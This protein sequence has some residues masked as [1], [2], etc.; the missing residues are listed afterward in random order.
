MRGLV[1]CAEHLFAKG[2]RYDNASED[3]GLIA[4]LLERVF[5]DE[6]WLHVRECFQR[7]ISF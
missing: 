3:W 6:L 2:G 1:K 7:W 4:M 5:D